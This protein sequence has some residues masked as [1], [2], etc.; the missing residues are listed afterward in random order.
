[1]CLVCYGYLH[2]TV[3]SQPF[4][5]LICTD[6]LLHAWFANPQVHVWSLTD[7]MINGKIMPMRTLE[8]PVGEQPTWVGWH[9]NGVHVLAAFGPELYAW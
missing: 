7:D 6:Q 1:M 9:P 8:G 5:K 3:H 2:V 4:N